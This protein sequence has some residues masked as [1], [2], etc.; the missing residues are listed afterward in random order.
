MTCKGV[1]IFLRL[2][3]KFSFV[4]ILTSLYAISAFSLV[5]IAVVF[6]YW[7]LEKHVEEDTKKLL[8]S[9]YEIIEEILRHHHIDA[10]RLKGEI[11]GVSHKI[12]GLYARLID[13]DGVVIAETLDMGKELS[14][15]FRCFEKEEYSSCFVHSRTEKSFHVLSSPLKEY[16]G[17]KLR[18]VI[19]FDQTREEMLIEDFRNVCL[20]ILLSTIFISLIL[21][22][23]ITKKGTEPLRNIAN[24]V[25][26][27]S[28]ETL[29][30]R[31]NTQKLP[32]ELKTLAEKFNEMMGRIEN[33]FS[34]LNRFS[35]DIAHELRTPINNL[36]GGD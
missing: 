17:G 11:D 23:V 7:T 4:Q 30:E 21:A 10:D 16:Y 34:Q 8:H 5:F 26:Q 6:F 31:L 3:E 12:P 36:R 29:N 25:A 1:H 32:E 35:T 15:E 18:V 27:I 2:S 19:G 22:F 24:S 20:W 33:S 28:S 13:A 14:S 9:R